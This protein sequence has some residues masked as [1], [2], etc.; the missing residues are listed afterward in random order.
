MLY[1]SVVISKKTIL[2]GGVE[3][4]NE[5]FRG[6]FKLKEQ[7]ELIIKNMASDDSEIIIC[8]TD[9][10][11]QS[12]GIEQLDIG[13]YTLNKFHEPIKLTREGANKR[14][15]SSRLTQSFHFFMFEPIFSP[16]NALNQ[17]I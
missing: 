2:D 16:V 6:L 11:C 17:P 3:Y 9:S 7:F 1:N 12:L 13:I 5:I 15:N 14:G 10:A 8:H 4:D